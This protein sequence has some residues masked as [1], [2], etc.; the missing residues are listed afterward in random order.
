MRSGASLDSCRHRR[1]VADPAAVAAVQEGAH[2][3][4]KLQRSAGD[5]GYSTQV[6]CSRRIAPCRQHEHAAGSMVEPAHLTS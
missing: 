6:T 1:R 4:G 2:P 5:R 3:S